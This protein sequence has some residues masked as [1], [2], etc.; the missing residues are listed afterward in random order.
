MADCSKL[1]EEL[2]IFVG[3]FSEFYYKLQ[4][5]LHSVLNQHFFLF[6]EAIGM[7]AIFVNCCIY[8]EKFREY[9]F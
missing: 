9:A 4:C 8:N 5:L 3:K 7:F 6:P 2:I 1:L